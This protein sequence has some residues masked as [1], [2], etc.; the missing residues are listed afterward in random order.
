[1]TTLTD[2]SITTRKTVRYAIFGLVALFVGRILLMGAINIYS[3]FFPPPPPPPTV[4]YGKL[5]P[6]SFPV[7]K[8]S[9]GLSFKLENSDGELP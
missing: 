9:E 8:S 3:Y 7:G 1:M 6:I 2:I 5:P 4:T